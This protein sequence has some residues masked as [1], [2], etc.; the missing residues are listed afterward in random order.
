MVCFLLSVWNI[1]CCVLIPA[2]LH[3]D[4][5]AES[6]LQ[7]GLIRFKLDIRMGCSGTTFLD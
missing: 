3:Y 2:Y 6:V 4:G 5:A 1:N 7:N